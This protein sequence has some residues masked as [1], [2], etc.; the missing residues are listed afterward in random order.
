M[1]ITRIAPTPSGFLHP[2]NAVNFLLTSW[3]AR[4]HGGRLLLR[5]DDLDAARVR[6]EYLDDVFRVVSWLG[7][8]IHGGPSDVAEFRRDYSQTL[9]T[10]YYR[11]E[12]RR[13]PEVFACR[14]SRRELAGGGPYPGT[15]RLAGLE[16]A[17]GRTALRAT[18][19]RP[20]P[21]PV[22]SRTVDV[23]AEMGDFVVWRRDDLPAYQLASVVDDRDLGVNAVVRGLDLFDS[24]AAQLFLAPLLGAQSFALADFRHHELV[25]DAAGR[26]LSKSAGQRAASIVGEVSLA[27]IGEAA[28]ALA[29][30][31][32]IRVP[33]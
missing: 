10:E 15:C 28:R 21:V 6:P 24:T 22:G 7:L 1:L 23:A 11:D 19:P 18:V 2:G 26:K 29:P 9:R 8:E 20:C 14:C 5:I 33:E 13:L 3:L 16:L 4:Q 25:V 31:I 32:G 30:E 17:A 12:V 27:S